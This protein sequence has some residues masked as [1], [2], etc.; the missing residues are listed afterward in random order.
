MLGFVT[1]MTRDLTNSKCFNFLYNALVIN[2]LKIESQIW[3]S[4]NPT[5]IHL[6]VQ[7]YMPRLSRLGMLRLGS[8]ILLNDSVFL[9][10][11]VNNAPTKDYS[12]FV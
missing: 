12:Q 3:S 10:S 1:R 2:G 11:I 8:Q 6:G 9:F 4:K 5:Q 7:Y